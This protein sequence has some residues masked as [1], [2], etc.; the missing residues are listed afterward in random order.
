MM[1]REVKAIQRDIEKAFGL[2]AA[3]AARHGK[4]QTD[5]ETAKVEGDGAAVADALRRLEAEAI[6][7]KAQDERLTALANEQA[8]TEKREREAADD[9]SDAALEVRMASQAKT[10]GRDHAKAFAPAVAFL[11]VQ[12]GN[13]EECAEANKRRG[14]RGLPPILTA[15]ERART[16]PGRIEPPEYADQVVWRKHSG[17]PLVSVFGR[18]KA[19]ELVP[20][21]VGAVKSVERVLVRA[22]REIPDQRPKSLVE[23][24][25]I[26]GFMPNDEPVWPPKGGR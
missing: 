7:I 16:I 3:A 14:A 12:A 4:A 11:A 24:V 21:E 1:G 25:V 26:P 2:R 23:A 15:E 20:Q 8:E 19:G 10:F 6:V 22:E 17:G 5:L 9:R 18:N 13:A